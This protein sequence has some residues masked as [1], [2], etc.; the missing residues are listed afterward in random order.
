MMKNVIVY[1]GNSFNKSTRFRK[2]GGKSVCLRARPSNRRD[3]NFVSSI[4]ISDISEINKGPGRIKKLKSEL[5]AE[6]ELRKQFGVFYIVSLVIFFIISIIPDTSSSTPYIQLAWSWAGLFLFLPPVI[7]LAQKTGMSLAELGI[8][9]FNIKKNI[10]EGV[11]FSSFLCVIMLVIRYLTVSDGESFFSWGSL[12]SFSRYLFIFHLSTYWIHSYLQEFITRGVLQ[13]L[14]QKFFKD[15][16]FMF[17]IFLISLLFC[18]VH[19]RISFL[20]SLLIFFVSLFYGYIYYRHK[21]LIGVSIVHCTT[22]MLAMA[23]GFF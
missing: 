18:V 4:P 5:R 23:T 14:T 1:S 11:F 7:F 9:F 13:G 8:T 16:H 19:I 22:G 20:F 2:T 17:P 6:T 21:N 12:T 10:T 3:S 15:S